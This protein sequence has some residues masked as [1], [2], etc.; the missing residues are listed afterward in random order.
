MEPPAKMR[1][2]CWMVNHPDLEDIPSP[3]ENS[4]CESVPSFTADNEAL[5]DIVE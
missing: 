4:E 2:V 5:G 3:S 1:R